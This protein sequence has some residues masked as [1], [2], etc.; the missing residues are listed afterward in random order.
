MRKGGVAHGGRAI[1]SDC[2]ADSQRVGD[3]RAQAVGRQCVIVRSRSRIIVHIRQSD[4]SRSG[5][6]CRGPPGA[7]LDS[8]C[9]PA[10]SGY[11]KAR[12]EVFAATSAYSEDTIEFKKALYS[13]AYRAVLRLNRNHPV[14][15]DVFERWQSGKRGDSDLARKEM[16]LLRWSAVCASSRE[17]SF[18]YDDTQLAPVMLDACEAIF[19]AHAKAKPPAAA[20]E[21]L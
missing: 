13:R 15:Q 12:E 16:T 18:S 8:A 11:C 14:V 7:G 1:I 2:N 6:R 21:T 3:T 9:R 4:S 19:A 17:W 20:F 5:G 10:R